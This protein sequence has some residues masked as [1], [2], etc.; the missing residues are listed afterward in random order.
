V[1]LFQV[2][3]TY[4]SHAL[5]SSSKGRTRQNDLSTAVLDSYEIAYISSKYLDDTK[6][7]PVRAAI[8]S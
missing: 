5:D 1:V 6:T 7:V 4:E 2:R 3:L 8:S